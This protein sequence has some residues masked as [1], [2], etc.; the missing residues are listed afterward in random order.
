MKY[1]HSTPL[2]QD[3]AGHVDVENAYS[4]DPARQVAG[5]SERDV[6]GV[7]APLWSETLQ[8]IADIDFMAFPRLPGYAEIGW[9]QPNG[10][11][12]NEY[13]DRLGAHAPRLVAMG[14]NFYRSPKVAWL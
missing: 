12:W 5:V 7:E 11:H 10:R 14:V 13:K 9:S 1:N 2:G 6:L 4:W 3:W 8:T